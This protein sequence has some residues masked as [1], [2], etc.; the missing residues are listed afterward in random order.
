VTTRAVALVSLLLITG[1]SFAEMT[2]EEREGEAIVRT[3]VYAA[4]VDTKTGVLTSVTDVASGRTVELSGPGLILVPERDREEWA[5]AWT[6]S[7]TIHREVSATTDVRFE[8]RQDAIVCVSEWASPVGAVRRTATFADGRPVVEIDYA[9]SATGVIEEIGYQIETR[10]RGL[11]TRGRIFPADERVLSPRDGMARHDPAPALAYCWDGDTGIG[12]MAG[13]DARAVAHAI[14]PGPNLV[15]LAAYSQPLR[16]TAPPF[17]AGLQVKLVIGVDPQEALALYRALTPGLKSVEIADLEIDRLIHWTDEAGGAT[18]IVFN[19]DDEARSV[20]VAAAVVSGLGQADALPEQVLGLGP[21]E[22]ARVRLRWPPLPEWGHGL[23]VRLLDA[24]GAQLDVAREYFAV[25]DN[26]SRVGQIV[27]FNPGWM[28]DDWRIPRYVEWARRNAIGTIEYYCWAPDQVFDLTPDA[29]VFEPHTESQGAYRAQLRRSFLQD[30]V[31]QAHEGGLRVLAMDTG[32]ASLPG[33]LSHPE[34]ARYTAEGQIYIYN[35]DIHDGK[36][37]NAVPAH[38]FTEERIRAWA[39][40]MADSVDMFGWDGVRFDWNFIPASPADPLDLDAE[41]ERDRNTWYDWQGRPA[42]ELFP[43]PDATGA[44]LCRLWRETVT[45][46]H[47]RFV[48]HGNYQVNAE[49]RDTFPQYTNAACADSGILREGLLNVALRYPTWQEW[50]DALM[51]TTRVIRPLGGQP[52][53]GWMR[54]YAPGSISHSV[55]QY[56]MISAGF[57]WYGSAGARHSIDDTW[58]RFRHA[59]RFSE[60]FYDPAF[61]PAE[62]ATVTG[63]GV[64]RVLWEPFVFVRDEGERRETLV[65]LVNLPESDHIIQRHAIPPVRENLTVTI[66]LPE[67][68]R[69]ESCHVLVPDPHPHAQPLDWVLAGAGHAVVTLPELREMASVLMVARKTDL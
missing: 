54:G 53:V 50:A 47:P 68:A 35:G 65:H 48:Y 24:D 64:E 19:N 41:G 61:L 12:L 9:V 38:V 57:H 67:G 4:S 39:T 11:F 69:V 31:V 10:D 13:G 26:F 16:W 3:D 8:Q 49:V 52:S 51:E 59:L 25:S 29:E 20:R 58:T 62:A 28:K 32:M 22:A 40:E 42:H 55:L 1:A 63:G 33:A 5:Q 30:L 18:A 7:P 14:E 23:E 46:R 21:G 27:V 66:D 43:E 60:Y 15:Q 45:S 36:R 17:E 34:Q 56:C 44:S 37:F 2:L 6:P